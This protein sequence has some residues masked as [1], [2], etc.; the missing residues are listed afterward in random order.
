M[1]LARLQQ[2]ITLGLVASAVA[3]TV[4]CLRAGRPVWA[5]VGAAVI[6]FGHAGVLALEMAMAARLNRRDPAPPARPGQRVHAWLAEV[7]WAPRV[8]CW[9]QPFR[10]RKWADHLPPQGRGVLLVH[11]FVCNRGFWNPW[12]ARLRAANIAHVAIDLEPVFGSIDD[13]CA[14]IEAGM[15][16]LEAATGRA[17]VIVAHSMG[18]LAV[19]AWLAGDDHAARV[20]HLVTIATPHHG[21]ELARWA[22]PPN[23]R[24]MRRD[25]PWL[26]AL[27][28]REAGR[29]AVPTTCFYGHCDNVV[30]PASAAVLEGAEAHHLPGTAHVHM[31]A[32]PAVYDA[33]IRALRD[34]RRPPTA[35]TSLRDPGPA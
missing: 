28:L 24:Q 26:A 1:T 3:W 34:P 18:G 20:H 16:R 32:H 30:M 17:P 7:A 2:A 4:A 27:A 22:V 14:A 15:R 25:S 6:A 21:T 35:R 12:M 11:G 29:A 9:Q 19:R 8:F 33:V 23:A 10:S 31:A 5:A 13:Y